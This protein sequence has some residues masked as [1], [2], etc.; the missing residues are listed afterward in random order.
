[1]NGFFFFR[2]ISEPIF[3]KS[4]RKSSSLGLFHDGYLGNLAEVFSVVL[5]VLSV[6]VVDVVEV[7]DGSWK[8]L[9]ESRTIIIKTSP[10]KSTVTLPTCYRNTPII[11]FCH[12]LGQQV[13]LRLQQEDDGNVISES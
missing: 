1:M 12:E 8:K 11:R 9:E 5:V 2:N 10:S 3:K 7:V 4:L 6:V 13:G